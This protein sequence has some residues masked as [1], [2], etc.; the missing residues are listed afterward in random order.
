MCCAFCTLVLIL[1]IFIIRS[2]GLTNRSSNFVTRSYKHSKQI[3]YL[4]NKFFF[5][6]SEMR[7]VTISIECRDKV[8]GLLRSIY[9]LKQTFQS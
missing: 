8:C 4:T 1:L 2:F 9:G 6:Y 5:F 7:D 3:S